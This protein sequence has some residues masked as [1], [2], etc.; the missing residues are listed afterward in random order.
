MDIVFE[1]KLII[2]KFILTGFPMEQIYGEYETRRKATKAALDYRWD[3]LMLCIQDAYGHLYSFMISPDRD[4][5]FITVWDITGTRQIWKGAVVLDENGYMSNEQIDEVMDRL[6]NF[7]DNRVKCSGC[8]EWTD[9]R[10]NSRRFYASIYCE[11]CWEKRY[12]KKAE[13][14][15]Y[16]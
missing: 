5:Y 15:N 14:E 6:R 12:K 1:P 8:D 7:S 4:G 2:S 13:K 16:G 9:V 3:N 11:K 10:D